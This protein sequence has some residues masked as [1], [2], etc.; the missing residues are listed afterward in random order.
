MQQR[1]HGQQQQEDRCGV[2]QDPEPRPSLAGDASPAP[3]STR[4][5][6]LSLIVTKLSGIVSGEQL[7]RGPTVLSWKPSSAARTSQLP[8]V[9]IHVPPPTEGCESVPF[10]TCA[11]HSRDASGNSSLFREAST[12]PSTVSSTWSEDRSQ[13]SAS[14]NRHQYHARKGRCRASMLPHNVCGDAS[15]NRVGHDRSGKR[16]MSQKWRRRRA[17]IEMHARIQE[18]RSE[19]C[20]R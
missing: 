17:I 11:C 2:E 4:D 3:A 14:P 19:S 10:L 9:E 5:S 18:R 16:E 12:P 1:C 7:A 6:P 8:V 15:S 13:V 20:S